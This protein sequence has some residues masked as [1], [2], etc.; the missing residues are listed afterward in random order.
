MNDE[1][2]AR[3]KEEKKTYFLQ[4][5]LSLSLSLSLSPSPSRSKVKVL[6]VAPKVSTIMLVSVTPEIPTCIPD[7]YIALSFN[8]QG[9]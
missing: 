4:S 6:Q 8:A 3:H 7:F 5:C 1:E 2:N 9:F